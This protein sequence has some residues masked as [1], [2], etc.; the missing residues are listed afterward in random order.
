MSIG[1]L[2]GDA[3]KAV[4]SNPA[5]DLY[6]VVRLPTPDRLRGRLRWDPERCTGCG[7]C[8]K[9]C[10]S[11]AIKV[12]IVD[13]KAKHYEF[14]YDMSLCLFCGQCAYSCRFDCLEL[15]H[16]DWELAAFERRSLGFDEVRLPDVDEEPVE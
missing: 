3:L 15:D 9:D 12:V 10:P 7:L 2:I 14:H 13:R 8:A 16:E 1:V 5:T 6:P 11:D 4:A